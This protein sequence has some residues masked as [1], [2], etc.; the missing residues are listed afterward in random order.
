MR[1]AICGSKITVQHGGSKGCDP[2][3]GCYQ[4]WR[5]G[6]SSC[7]NRLTIRASVTDNALLAAC[8]WRIP[9][10]AAN[11]ADNNPRS[12]DFAEP[13]PAVRFVDSINGL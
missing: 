10:F 12:C 5:N 11:S 2:R 3:Y 7:P 13:V 1:C 4:S 6:V 9:N 8:Q